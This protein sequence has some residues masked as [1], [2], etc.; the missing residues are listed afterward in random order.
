MDF[1]S[2]L[3]WRGMLHDMTP[4]LEEQLAQGPTKGYV[5]FDP[6]ADSLHIGN[7]VPVMMLV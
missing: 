3:R 5:G 7:L 4:G 1:I 2:E 6:T